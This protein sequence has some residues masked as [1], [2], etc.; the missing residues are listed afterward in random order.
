MT[1][2]IL[3]IEDDPGT[4][5]FLKHCL[6]LEGYRVS[7]SRNGLQGLRM[8]QQEK[9]D[10]IVLDVMLPGLDGYELCHQLR[11]APQTE[12][13]PVLM[14]SAKAR[15]VDRSTGIVVGANDYLAKPADPAEIV[16]RVK[17]LLALAQK[18][19]T[20][21]KMIAFLGSKKGVGATTI[22]VNVA[23][24]LSQKGKQVLVVDLCPGDGN[25][26]EHLGL[27]PV[28]AIAELLAKPAGAVSRRDLEAAMAVHHT[29]VEL[30]V[31][32]SPPDGR[33][34]ISA[35]D[36]ELLL[37]SLRDVTDY[38]LV[39]SPFQDSDAEKAVLTRCDLIIIV[40]DSNV[41]SLPRIKSTASLLC[42]SGILQERMS[43][44]IV[45]HDAIF[46]EAEFFKM[47]ST[48][49]RSTGIS[50][51]GIIPYDSKASLELVPG[52]IPV[53]LSNPSSPIAWA[54]RGTAQHVIEREK[55]LARR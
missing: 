51:L 28:H 39:D 14:L 41:D 45:D 48:I 42:L 24:A 30:L 4:L 38:I 3:V 50:L 6:E 13:T 52:G 27:K 33:Q 1:E 9:P 37:E 16:S 22:L 21:S 18:P 20:R 2:K 47:K 26:A 32:A 55:E 17:N 53:T 31:I 7:T 44:V 43:A 35:S 11:A 8:I 15:E 19:A 29:G 12:Q 5:R 10:L 40:T 34:D 25:A 46:D 49:E 23:I 54:I 36:L